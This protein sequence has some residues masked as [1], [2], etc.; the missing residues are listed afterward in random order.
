M[1]KSRSKTIVNAGYLFILINFLLAVFNLLVGFLSNSLAIASDAIHSLTDSVSGFLIIISEKL[2]NHKKLKNHRVKIERIT[3][4]VIA[5][6][7]IAVGVEI[8]IASI[9]NIITPEEVDYSIPTIIVVIAS[10]A[11]KYLLARYL[12][13]TG[14]A[15]KSNVLIASGAETLNDTWISVA[16]LVSALIYVI[17]KVDISSYISLAISL[18]IVKVG[19]EFIFPHLTHHHHHHLEQNPDHDHC[20][21]SN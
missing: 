9:K 12:K 4:I 6:I 5:L 3:T 20:G 13:T 11:T 7:I 14:K 15:I 10:V 21:K 16:V 18:V 19:L 17:F 8:I 1:E 2:A